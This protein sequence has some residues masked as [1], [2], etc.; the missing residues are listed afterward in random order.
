MLSTVDTVSAKESTQEWHSKCRFKRIL[1]LKKK[2]KKKNSL[3]THP[4]AVP[5]LF[6]LFIFSIYYLF[7]SNS[8]HAVGFS[9]H[10]KWFGEELNNILCI[11]HDNCDCL[12]ALKAIN[13]CPRKERGA[14]IAGTTG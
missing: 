3:F 10:T 4:D 1:H 14:N 6:A 11:V 8:T 12:I 2:T 5:M 7:F 13:T 9:G